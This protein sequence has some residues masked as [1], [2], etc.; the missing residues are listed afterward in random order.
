MDIYRELK[1]VQYYYDRMSM[2]LKESLG[3]KERVKFFVDLLN[4]I[5][6]IYDGEIL[7]KTDIKAK[8][9]YVE[10][11]KFLFLDAYYKLSS[12]SSRTLYVEPS[13]EYHMI[14]FSVS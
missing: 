2:F 4:K 3:I 6:E 9:R 12:A 1:E 10:G 11:T 14:F 5:D 8:C 7:N 13:L